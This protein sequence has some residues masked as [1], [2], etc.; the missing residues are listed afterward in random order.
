[1]KIGTSC[2]LTNC[3][4]AIWLGDG[5]QG[6]CYG[7]TGLSFL[8]FC[9]DKVVAVIADTSIMSGVFSPEIGSVPVV[10]S[11]HEAVKLGANT[12][13]IGIAPYGGQM[14]AEL[15]HDLKDA[16]E[17]DLFI[18][19]GLHTEIFP[20][21][22]SKQHK[23]LNIRHQQFPIGTASALA[24]NLTCRRVLTIGTNMS[25]GK[26]TSA[27]CLN[28]EFR[29]RSINSKFIATGQGGI[30]I[31]GRGIALDALPLDFAA[32]ALEQ[33]IL[34]YASDSD[35]LIVEGQGSLLHPGSSI[36]LALLRGCC[37]TDL[38]LCHAPDELPSSL[39][40]EA[41]SLKELADIYVQ[42]ASIIPQ[43]PK[44]IL[45]AIAINS[46]ILGKHSEKYSMFIS[47]FL[48]IPVVDATSITGSATLANCFC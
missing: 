30:M 11:I 47:N 3:R 34:D 21:N 45:Q 33:M 39:E 12:F 27:L 17:Y 15:Y 1:M 41:A 32:Y 16:F 22:T 10:R 2:D 26:M 42:L 37:P 13:L 25:V 48:G 36:T 46:S 28:A 23:I 35:I 18:V 8:R 9:R 44:P 4:V 7:K 40:N 29:R 6:G 14:P 20:P 19:N 5:I 38:I 43:S 31:S 24:A